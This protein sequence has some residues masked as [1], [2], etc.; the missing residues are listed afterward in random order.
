M[1]S[2]KL[3]GAFL[4]FL[5]AVA[6]VLASFAVVATA[7]AQ[8]ADDSTTST[9]ST[10]TTA[11]TDQ[12][13][14]TP[15]VFAN[16]VTVGGVQVGGMTSDEA[17]ATIESDFGKS[18][19]L[20]IAN[21]KVALSPGKIS[22]RAEIDQALGRAVTAAPGQSVS[23]KVR[24]NL[25][26]LHKYTLK[27]ARRFDRK[28]IEPRVRLRRL[29]PA[30]SKG[31]VGRKLKIKSDERLIRAAFK[32]NRRTPLK[33][34]VKTIQRHVTRAHFGPV[35]VIRRGSNRL[36]LY[37]GVRFW[38]RFGVATGQPAYPTPTGHF[39]IAVMWKNPTWTPPD[40]PWAAGASPIGPGP[41]NPLGTR[42]MGLSA[43]GVGIHGTPNS[44]SIGY[45]A[46]HG[47]I[48]MYISDAEW[49]FNHVHI[50][51]QVFIVS[52]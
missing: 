52:R 40:S 41:G 6:G 3:T 47:C 50:G 29:R 14:T 4:G 16:G 26:K 21:K 46:S 12:T 30:I 10:T 25:S 51:T 27:L 36:Y 8:I 34:R 15:F 43:P 28:P 32:S 48:R 44:A 20:R 17:R 38:R 37:K 39:E 33:L 2:N 13:I 18:L 1:R 7:P 22:A 31:R 9:T 45:S 11:T 42:W 5:L 19:L 23:L 49:L 35:I 24:V